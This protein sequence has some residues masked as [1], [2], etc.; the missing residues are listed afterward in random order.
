MNHLSSRTHR[1][2][3]W[4][5]WGAALC[6]AA[7]AL[8]RQLAG[9]AL[10]CLW[11][12]ALVFSLP[13]GRGDLCPAGHPARA[14]ARAWMAACAASVA[15]YGAAAVAWGE[16]WYSQAGGFRLLLTSVAV[17][18]IVRHGGLHIVWRQRFGHA[19]AIACLSACAWA[20]FTPARQFTTNAIPWAAGI[21]F[22]SCVLL[23]L[24]LRTDVGHRT[25]ALW[26]A[27]ALAA[28]L[29]VVLSGSRGAWP[30]LPWLVIGA[31]IGC[32]RLHHSLARAGSSRLLHI[33]VLAAPLLALAAAVAFPPALSDP[34]Q[35]VS[36]GLS[37]IQP[38]LDELPGSAD[39]SIGARLALWTLGLEAF[40]ESPWLGIGEAEKQRRIQAKAVRLESPLLAKLG[41]LHNDY[42]EHMA[43]YGLV[44]LASLLSLGA[45][46]AVAAVRV[47]AFDRT[48]F[49]QLSGILFVHSLCE[50]TNVNLYHKYYDVMLAACVGIVLISLPKKQGA[51]TAH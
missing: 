25:R 16:N 6:V 46:L 34:A 50:L 22:A 32:W 40:R 15:I 19:L 35:R 38:A 11:L 36:T 20:L 42:L 27:A 24:G 28:G 43:L 39:S 12:A 2:A 30:V 9:A 26:I 33:S 29:A 3:S 18:A 51:A 7:S 47:R 23:P 45:G 48:A 21:A 37:E 5:V 41:H 4:L 49:W 31:A 14:A 13:A 10:L 17:W 44:G 8:S 1:L